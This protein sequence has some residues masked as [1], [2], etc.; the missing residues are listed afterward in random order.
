LVF[1]SVHYRLLPE[2]TIRQMAGDVAKAVRW[3]RDHAGNW[4]SH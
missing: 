4:R 3:V 1:V 2:A